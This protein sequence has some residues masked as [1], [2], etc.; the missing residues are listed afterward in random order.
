MSMPDIIRRHRQEQF[1]AD[2]LM[3]PSASMRR[4]AVWLA[5]AAHRECDRIVMGE[6]RTL[7]S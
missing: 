3:H 6:C 2:R 7:L 5:M 1:A 4:R